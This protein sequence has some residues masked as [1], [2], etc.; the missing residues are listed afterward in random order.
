MLILLTGDILGVV[1]QAGSVS[2]VSP[3]VRYRLTATRSSCGDILGVVCQAGSV[4]VVQ[5]D[6]L[7]PSHYHSQFLVVLLI[8]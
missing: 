6:R 8:E 1:C 7:L 3:T 4:S 5:P 2:V